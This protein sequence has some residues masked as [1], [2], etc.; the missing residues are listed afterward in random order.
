MHRTDGLAMLFE[1]ALQSEPPERGKPR[2]RGKP[3]SRGIGVLLVV[4]LIMVSTAP[5][6]GVP[7]L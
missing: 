1:Q 2:K 3:G 7:W 5:W 6:V 4:V